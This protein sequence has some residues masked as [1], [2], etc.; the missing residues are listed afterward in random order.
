MLLLLYRNRYL[1]DQTISIQTF[2]LNSNRWL[3]YIMLGPPEVLIA[4][5]RFSDDMDLYSQLT[6]TF[7]YIHKRIRLI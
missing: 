4:L 5:S 3:S 2:L 7:H 6:K 1:K